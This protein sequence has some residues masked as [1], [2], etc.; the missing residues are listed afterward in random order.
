MN[1]QDTGQQS[2]RIEHQFHREETA[3]SE[4][5]SSSSVF[6]S[7]YTYN[8]FT[9]AYRLNVNLGQDEALHRLLTYR[10][11]KCVC[12]VH[13]RSSITNNNNDAVTDQGL[14]AIF[15]ALGELPYLQKLKMDFVGRPLRIPVAALTAVL[16]QVTQLTSLILEEVRLA[17]SPDELEE[18]ADALRNHPSLKLV[19]LHGCVPAEG[20]G[21]TL[22]P[23]VTAMAHCATLEEI[24]LRDTRM[25]PNSGTET[26]TEDERAG[27]PLTELCQSSSLRVLTLRD[28][29]EIHDKHIELMAQ[30][31][32]HNTALREL[33]VCSAN[34]GKRSGKAMG[35][36]LRLNRHLQKLE[37]QLDSGEHA[38]PITEVLQMNSTLKRLDLFFNGTI[39]AR[40][41][42]AF[43]EMLRKNYVL[44]DLNGSVW[45]GQ[46]NLEIDFYLRLN[47]AGRANL[48]TEHA[49]RAQWIET[50]ISQKQDLSII[51]SLVLMNPLVCLTD[52][53]D[54]MDV[55]NNGASSSLHLRKRRK[56]EQ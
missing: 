18:L 56:G 25:S 47:R 19:Y 44:L 53:N 34:L 37:I 35:Q 26:T 7:T 42:E 17:G 20:S 32:V 6:I 9:M 8:Y 51:F 40:I 12:L 50:L 14:Y 23:L 3:E 43:T 33:T 31:L 28:M 36:V 54:F 45:R 41:R 2:K 22:D 46:S 15:D 38:I 39:S 4:P 48:L 11:E 21:I 29:T 30:R 52:P 49:T 27:T 24:L 10:E 16:R 13:D 1:S 5:V 55:S